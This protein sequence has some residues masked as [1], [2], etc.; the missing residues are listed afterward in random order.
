[1]FSSVSASAPAKVILFGEHAVVYGQP[2]IAA[3]I[4]DLTAKVHITPSK[5]IH[6]RIIAPLLNVNSQL[7]ELPANNP[8]RQMVKILFRSL[9]HKNMR[10]S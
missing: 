1:M 6:T 4:P 10:L 3:P 5:S 9:D 8:L 7:E 2:A